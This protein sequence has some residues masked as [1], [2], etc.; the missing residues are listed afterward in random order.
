MD[1]VTRRLEELANCW[2]K[3]ERLEIETWTE[4]QLLLKEL[5]DMEQELKELELQQ[6]R[7][8][9]LLAEQGYNAKQ[10][11][12]SSNLNTLSQTSSLKDETDGADNQ[13]VHSYDSPNHTFDQIIATS[14]GGTGNPSSQLADK[15]RDVFCLGSE[16]LLTGKQLPVD[17]A[18]IAS[19]PPVRNDWLLASPSAILLLPPQPVIAQLPAPV[20]NLRPALPACPAKRP[21]QL[22][23]SA[24]SGVGGAAVG[25]TSL[26]I[27]S[28]EYSDR[29]GKVSPGSPSMTAK[30]PARSPR[31][32]PRL[33]LTSSSSSLSSR[34]LN[35]NK[36]LNIGAVLPS[37]P[38]AAGTGI[39]RMVP[40][41]LLAPCC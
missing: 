25:M 7:N 34:C 9:D 21:A 41:T 18:S 38:A 36:R 13:P 27:P 33:S 29:V 14:S 37:K 24:A 4:S 17:P 28:A 3:D 15:G 5:A 10:E 40:P 11:C 26:W 31:I 12:F 2:Q 32:R 8:D 6:T 39:H 22:D 30:E 35:L 23:K 16:K 20:A 1:R 19:F